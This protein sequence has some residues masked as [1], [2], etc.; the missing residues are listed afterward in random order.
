[1]SITVS[2]FGPRQDI[3]RLFLPFA[4]FVFLIVLRFSDDV[5]TNSNKKKRREKGSETERGRQ[6][7]E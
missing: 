7:F 4:L 6:H 2:D 5:T 3:Y 1:M